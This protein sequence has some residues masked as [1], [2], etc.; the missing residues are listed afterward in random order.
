MGGLNAILKGLKAV[1]CGNASSYHR[2]NQGLSY[3]MSQLLVFGPD[4]QMQH[5]LLFGKP[6]RAF[7][8]K[9]DI[10]RFTWPRLNLGMVTIERI[11]QSACLLPK[12]DQLVYGRASETERVWVDVEGISNLSRLKIQS[13]PLGKLRGIRVLTQVK[14]LT[15]FIVT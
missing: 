7:R 1:V 4:S 2:K 5:T 11:G 6:L 14:H 12:D 9:G 3:T 15:N 8:T 13:I 10:E